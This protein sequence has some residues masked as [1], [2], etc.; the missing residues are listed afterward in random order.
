MKHNHL[1]SALKHLKETYNIDGLRDII[2]NQYDLIILYCDI[3]NRTNINLRVLAGNLETI[4]LLNV[5][6]IQF[7]DL[8]SKF[9]LKNNYAEVAGEKEFYDQIYNAI[10][11]FEST[12]NVTFPIIT[13]KGRFWINAKVSRLDENPNICSIYISNITKSMEEEEKLFIKTHKDSLT[14]V[15]NRY[16]LDY[17]YGKRYKLPNFHVF[18]IDIDDFKNINDLLGHQKGNEY[19]EAFAK[20][21]LS[22]ENNYSRFYRIG[23]DEFVG[24]FFE[25]SGEILRIAEAIIDETTSLKTKLDLPHSSV[26]IGIVKATVREDVI[27]KADKVMYEAKRLGKNRYLFSIEKN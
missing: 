19:L 15:F 20:I 27:R 2:L 11:T 26:T 8:M 25:E 17:H 5:P 13:K 12:V 1:D 6:S 9:D 23:G 21:L 3:S 14:Q 24:L 7:E 18:Y 10:L 22:Y 4:G 16:T